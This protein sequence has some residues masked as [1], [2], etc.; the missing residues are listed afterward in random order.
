MFDGVLPTVLSADDTAITVAQRERREN[1]TQLSEFVSAQL[2][3]L[4]RLHV[5]TL[6]MRG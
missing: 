3:E 5:S 6:R 1:V 4:A 2:W